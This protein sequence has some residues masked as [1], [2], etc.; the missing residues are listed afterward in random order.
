MQI[1]TQI[2]GMISSSSFNAKGGW[3][4][5]VSSAI[6]L[7]PSLHLIRYATSSTSNP[8]HFFQLVSSLSTSAFLAFAA[9]S[10]RASMPSL[11]RYHHPF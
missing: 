2:L 3:V 10:L 4:H 9:H 11:D 8:I 6:A 7:T 5:L 1:S